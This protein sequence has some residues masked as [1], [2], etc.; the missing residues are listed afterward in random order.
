MSSSEGL[1][2]P[3]NPQNILFLGYAHS[4]LISL[5]L[6][7]HPPANIERNLEPQ[8]K[9]SSES[10]ISHDPRALR[11]SRIL[12]YPSRLTHLTSPDLTHPN[13]ASRQTTPSRT[14]LNP[15]IPSISPHH[16]SPYHSIKTS[17]SPSLF[18]ISTPEIPA[19]PSRVTFPTFTYLISPTHH[20]LTN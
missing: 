6:S 4:L 12:F 19:I 11:A 16:A 10:L 18:S 17:L 5:L 14:R 15:S 3:C 2:K 20:P 9:I 8:M 13:P 1:F 7:S